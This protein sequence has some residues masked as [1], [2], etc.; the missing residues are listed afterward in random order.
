MVSTPG[1]SKTLKILRTF[2]QLVEFVPGIPSNGR[3]CIKISKSLGVLALF[4]CQLISDVLKRRASRGHCSPHFKSQFRHKTE[5]LKLFPFF[6]D[7]SPPPDDAVATW[8]LLERNP[9]IFTGVDFWP[10]PCVWCRVCGVESEPASGW[11]EKDRETERQ[12]GREGG[13]EVTRPPP[14]RYL[15]YTD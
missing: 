4:E 5:Y 10:E 6:K 3:S 8:P 13:R 15:L 7:P 1:E 14:S 12:R 9:E 11:G 2:S